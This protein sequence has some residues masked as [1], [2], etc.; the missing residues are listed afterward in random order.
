[1]ALR[2]RDRGLAGAVAR[3]AAGRAGALRA[4]AFPVAVVF[5]AGAFFAVALRVV[6]DE[7]AVAFF[8]GAFLA[9]VFDAG[10]FLAVVFFAGAFLAAVVFFAGAFLAAVVFFAGAFLAAVVFFAAVVFLAAVPVVF[11]AAVRVVFFA[12]LVVFAAAF[13]AGAFVAV[14]FDAGAFFAAVLEAGAFF[15]VVLD[16]GAFFAAVFFAAVAVVAGVRPDPAPDAFAEALPADAFRAAA[17]VVVD[18]RAAVLRVAPAVR[19]AAADFLAAG[20]VVA[21]CASA[22]SVPSLGTCARV[23]PLRRHGVPRHG[24]SRAVQLPSPAQ[25]AS[26]ASHASL[27]SRTVCRAF[28]ASADES[29][30]PRTCFAGH[31]SASVSTRWCRVHQ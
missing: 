25:R 16:A 3:A 21:C 8:A 19:S 15:A 20:R 14:A 17:V 26:S 29:Y 7:V 6:V 31:T 22:I 9:V 23:P 4:V 18:R 13:L 27:R 2:A 24:P 12:A 10:A 11:F 28:S 5:F 1:M 30:G